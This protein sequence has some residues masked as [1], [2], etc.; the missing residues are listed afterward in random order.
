MQRALALEA[1]PPLSFALRFFLAAP[2]YVLLSGLLLLYAGPSALASRWQPAIL[3]LTHLLA[4]GAIAQAMFGALLQILPVATG[5]RSFHSAPLVGGIHLSLNLG[6][7]SLAGAFL[8]GQPLLF[9]AASILLA[10]A[11]G[12]FLLTLAWALWR[13]RA[14]RTK[15][16]PTILLAV[17]LALIALLLTVLLGLFLA[18]HY[19]FSWPLPRWLTDM[20]AAWGLLGWVGLLVIGISFQVIPIFQVTER[21]PDGV[22]H[23]L[24]L[25]LFIFLLILSAAL[26][27][28]RSSPVMG[29]GPSSPKFWLSWLLLG[30]AF[31]AWVALQLLKNRKRP[32]PDTTTVFWRTAYFSL[33]AILLLWGGGQLL[34]LL[35]SAAAL[36]SSISLKLPLWL[37]GLALLGFAW[38]AINGMQY[39]ILPFLLWFNAQRNAPVVIRELP[40]VRHYLPDAQ[41]RPQ[42]Y[43]HG[44]S[45]LLFA[46]ALGG[47][48]ILIYPAAAVLCLSTLWFYKNIAYALRQYQAALQLIA[49]RVE[50]E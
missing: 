48:P 18:N 15:G 39:T 33:I 42:W 7:L 14:R 37:G 9:L 22:T 24:A 49:S 29:W 38:S 34:P 11:F 2:F 12:A 16:A 31:Y 47:M 25:V 26:Y 3:A 32:H 36:S 41:A 35:P 43:V 10:L 19:S 13:D 45:L 6:T 30:F 40:R 5:I 23:W 4:L 46:L 21:F 28:A 8:T 44:L 27:W 17:R 50:S 1:S 20:H